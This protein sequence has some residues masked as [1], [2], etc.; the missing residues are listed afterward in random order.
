MVFQ[1]FK[2]KKCAKPVKYS[3]PI[4]NIIKVDDSNFKAN[5][6]ISAKNIKESPEPLLISEH[7]VNNTS[8]EDTLN[9]RRIIWKHL[10]KNGTSLF[11][12]KIKK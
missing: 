5:K 7:M 9:R 6:K 3:T 8:D 11:K 10:S 2:I 1:S 4:N 12:N